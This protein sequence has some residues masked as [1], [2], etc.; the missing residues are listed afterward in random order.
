MFI[1]EDGLITDY[2]CSADYP[3]EVDRQ[4]REHMLEWAR[5]LPGQARVRLGK[6]G[7]MQGSEVNLKRMEHE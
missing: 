6:V 5:S 2:I 7:T 1:Y 4:V 3:P